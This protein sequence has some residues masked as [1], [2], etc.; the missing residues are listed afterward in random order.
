MPILKI[1]LTDHY[2]NL[3]D[4]FIV[5]GRFANASEVVRAGLRL[6]EREEAEFRAKLEWLRGATQEAC[7]ELDHGEGIRL[8]SAGEIDSFVNDVLEKVRTA[9]HQKHGT[10]VVTPSP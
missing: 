8:A 4:E 2:A 1:D 3:I 7:A 5:A 6:L 9:L 10:N